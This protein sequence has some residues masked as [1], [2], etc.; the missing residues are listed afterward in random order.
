MIW[1]VTVRLLIYG[2]VMILTLAPDGCTLCGGD[3]KEMRGVCNSRAGG[4]Y[5]GAALPQ[6]C[7]TGVDRFFMGALPPYPR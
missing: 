1:F 5:G 4:T 2:G 7:L 6:F 3:C